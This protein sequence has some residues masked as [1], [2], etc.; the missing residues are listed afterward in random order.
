MFAKKNLLQ[1][2]SIVMGLFL[3]ACTTTTPASEKVYPYSFNTLKIEYNVTGNQAGNITEYFKNDQTATTLVLEDK[4][5][6]KINVTILGLKE[7]NITFDNE[8]KKGTQSPNGLYDEL[9]KM[10]MEKRMEYL[11]RLKTNSVKSTVPQIKEKRIIA[12]KECNLYE[13]APGTEVCLWEGY[14]LYSKLTTQT[15]TLEQVATKIETNPELPDSL[16]EIPKDIQFATTS[17]T[18]Q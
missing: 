14:Q 3:V 4:A 15:M 16:F 5:Q 13:L 18:Q 7:K 17:T 9:K 10:P 1:G 8:T 12:G 6:K 11:L 2:S